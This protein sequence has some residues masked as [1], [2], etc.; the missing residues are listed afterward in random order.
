MVY[1]PYRRLIAAPCTLNSPPVVSFNFALL[2]FLLSSVTRTAPPRPSGNVGQ[3]LG[4][5][6]KFLCGI[7]GVGRLK[8]IRPWYTGLLAVTLEQRR[9]RS[10]SM[11]GTP[12]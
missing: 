3:G 9:R 12:P 11:V 6:I 10:E 1:I 4:S 7:L 2:A 5:R 8:E